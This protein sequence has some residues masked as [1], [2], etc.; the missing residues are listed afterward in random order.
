MEE[1]QLTSFNHASI[2]EIRS[3]IDL[4]ERKT[5]YKFIRLEMGVPFGEPPKL[6][7]EAEI[8]ALKDENV[9][10]QYAPIEG[11]AELKQFASTFAF[12]FLNINIHPDNCL[13]TVGSINGAYLA[14][15][16]AFKRD[17]NRDQL[18]FLDPGFSVHKQMIKMLGMKE[19]SLDIYNYR[20]DKL[21]SAIENLLKTGKVSA[22]LF[23]NP[24]N[25][26][27][28]NLTQDELK[29]IGELADQY[30]VIVIEDLAYFGMDFR[31]E[32]NLVPTVAHFTK[33][34]ITLI[35]TSK[36]FNYAGQRI[37]LMLIND[38]LAT[39]SFK[40][41]S[42][43]F[44]SD[45]FIAAVMNAIYVTTAG[46]THSAQVALSSILKATI[47]DSFKLT[48]AVQAI[49]NIT[50]KVKQL[51]MENGFTIPYIKDLH[52]TKVIGDG[53][54]FTIAFD[55]FS[56]EELVRE[57]F[58]YGISTISLAQTGA[59]KNEAVRISLSLVKESD[60]VEL[61][62]RLKLFRENVKLP[63]LKNHLHEKNPLA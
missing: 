43:H 5:G 26:T 50:K 27:W 46:P 6:M 55:G 52:P 2:R 23:S 37:G 18:L 11:I 58:Y 39:R 16:V 45:K 30:G 42:N 9:A 54:Y 53:F 31:N 38:N 57:L 25:P 13:P 8:K 15:L 63:P 3:L 20:G 29:I 32:S 17:A 56:G 33:N 49:A 59:L 47:N 14:T 22:L 10:G 7:I 51:F 61:E 44:T 34:A 21:R 35:S 36:L 62:K 41:L 40:N 1:Q 19:L 60:L 28:M 24:N 12:K 48:S 4:I